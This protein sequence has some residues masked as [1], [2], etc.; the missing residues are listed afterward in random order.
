MNTHG[1]FLT[2]GATAL[3]LTL[4]SA[5]ATAGGP[6]G[7]GLVVGE[8]VHTRY[9]GVT[10]DLLT[11]GLGR[12]GLAN[13]APPA[14]AD[15]VNPTAEELRRLAIYNNY[16]ALVDTVAGGGYGTLYGP[17]VTADGTVTDSEG[18]VAG[19]E[20]LAYARSRRGAKVVVMVQVPDSFEP[21]DACMVT[22]P[23]SGSRGVYGAIGTA[24]EWG[25]KRGCAVVYTDKG[26]GTGAHNLA[27]D[28][29]QG[30]RG[31][32]L[33]ADGNRREA[34]F[35]ARLADPVRARFDEAFPNRFA[36]K[37]A[38]SQV[39]PE[40]D[41]GANVLS[42]IEFGFQVLNRQF[43]SG[44][45]RGSRAITPENTLV[46]ASSVSN[47]GGSSVRAAEQDRRGLIDGVAVS[48][49]NVN[50]EVSRGF[51]IQQGDAEPITGH[52]RSLYDYSTALAVYQ[53]CANRA[54]ENAGA[55]LLVL[56]NAAVN[57]NTCAALAARGLVTGSTVAEQATDAQRILNEEFA[58][59]PEQ[60]P[61]QPVQYAINVPQAIAITYANAYGRF[62]VLENLCAF[63]FGATGGD[64]SPVPLPPAAEAALFATSNGIPPTGGV[65]AIYN[66][67]TGG[68]IN[69]AL[70]TSPTSGLQDYSLDGFL[71]L[72]SL[73]EGRDPVTGSRF[74]GGERHEARR[75]A[76]GIEE[77][78]ASGDL[79]STPAV[80]VTGRADAIL[81]I[82]HTSRPY[83]GLNQELEGDDS[84]LRYYEVLNAQHL[85]VL[86]GL[87][88]FNERFIP[89]HHYFNQAMDLIY[90]H[91]KNGTPL[92][93]SQVVRTTPR[94]PGA[95]PITVEAN[96]PAI[97][98]DPPEADRIV[99]DADADLLR[100]P[101]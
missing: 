65:N 47:G 17:N 43:G 28:T 86:N 70:G 59:Q 84:G 77:I 82:N 40:A 30:L 22:A 87:A 35:I 72:R 51:A 99:F 34:H 75:V 13:P 50:P 91:L 36:F 95:P 42:S 41:W 81:P 66:E 53:G 93:P 74:R 38:H 44:K 11:A 63:S 31:Q 69:I 46:I 16:R 58:V 7:G 88:G 54:P 85:D 76:R 80:F 15:P 29:V 10:N 26:S 92:P 94:G 73:A 89:L 49:P 67:S 62:S 96:L 39:N 6:R 83:Y 101:E 19:D 3:A 12:T 33:E 27:T 20:Y 18:Q 14:F 56:N 48:E 25:L 68:P 100:I 32:L 37:H 1:L 45:G 71:C 21:S 57:E 98:A 55:P 8:V 9:D 23:S 4:G 79:D 78:R 2:A 52:S 64:G 97:Q 61:V 90:D 5:A 60:N 24:G